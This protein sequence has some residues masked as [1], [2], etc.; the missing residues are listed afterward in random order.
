MGTSASEAEV[1][2]YFQTLS[3]WGRWGPTDQLGTVN[4]VTPKRRREAAALVR[5][6]ITVSC[7]QDIEAQPMADPSFRTPH[8]IMLA[9][10]EPSD[11]PGAV[12]GGSLTFASEHLGLVY[13]GLTVTHLDG[14]GHAFWQGRMYNGYPVER[15]TT[16]GGAL[17]LPM[18]VL[19]DGVVT[20]GVLLDVAALRGRAWLE[21]GEDVYPEDLD[22]AEA[23]QGVQVAE[24]D[25][26]LL[27]TG[28]HRRQQAAHEQGRTPDPNYASWDALCLPWLHARR[29]A[30]IGSD[31]AN[32]VT[33]AAYRTAINP[34][35]AVGI[36][37][38][39]L[40]L[41]DNCDLEALSATCERLKRWEFQFALAPLRWTGAT[42]SPVNP[43]AE[44]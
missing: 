14:L 32:S 35:H 39:G 42:G 5:E 25:V 12:G 31:T 20:R 22:R 33:P 2:V 1:L 15:V 24:G 38:M 36:V 17:D 40:W 7:A 26:V 43:L 16:E 34:I 8:R 13:H 41:L 3:N 29:V 18:T 6:G 11:A 27:R 28:Y 9:T 4:F 23:H 19:S 21:P 30:I 37:A 44:F 10:G